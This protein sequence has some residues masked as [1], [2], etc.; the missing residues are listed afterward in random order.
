M[1]TAVPMTPPLDTTQQTAGAEPH[2]SPPDPAQ[3]Q[4][5]EYLNGWKRALADY[6]NL[7]KAMAHHAV[8]MREFQ[9]MNFFESLIPIVDLYA[10]ALQHVPAR[11]QATP[12]FQG[13]KQIQVQ[14]QQFMKDNDVT[15]EETGPA[16][17][18]TRQEAVE[19]VIDE[20]QPDG[21]ILLVVSPGYVYKNR[22]VR[23]A[24]VV[25][26]KLTN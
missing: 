15:Q 24:K 6:D 11:E 5:Q 16:F 4:L 17:D 14:L 1:T 8:E 25:V 12:W 7:K 18:P 9:V 10:T 19:T 13:F 23:P 2:A 26:N 21:A 22:L 3:V 20:K